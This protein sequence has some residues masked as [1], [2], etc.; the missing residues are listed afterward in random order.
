MNPWKDASCVPVLT[1]RVFNLSLDIL[2]LC[3][4]A[5]GPGLFFPIVRNMSSCAV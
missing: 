3:S 2:M 1:Q 5:S 4:S